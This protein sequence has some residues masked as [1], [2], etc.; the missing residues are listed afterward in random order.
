[1]R[2]LIVFLLAANVLS[3]QTFKTKEQLVHTFSIVARDEKTGEAGVGA[4]ATQSFVDKSYGVKGL[5]LLKKGFTAQQALDSLTKADAG[6]EVRQ[7]AIIDSKG[8]VAAHT[9]KNCI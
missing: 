8:N 3:A 4:I 7:V 2:L 6:R 5:E 9:G 1:M